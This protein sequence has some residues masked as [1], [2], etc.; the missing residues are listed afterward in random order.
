MNVKRGKKNFEETGIADVA[1][2]L[3]AKRTHLG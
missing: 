1:M 3:T 2:V